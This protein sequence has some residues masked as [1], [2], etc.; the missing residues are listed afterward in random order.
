MEDRYA[1]ETREE[2][3]ARKARERAR[4]K[5]ILLIIS[6]IVVILAALIIV[7]L[8]VFLKGH[9]DAETNAIVGTEDVNSFSIT[10]VG[11]K[12]DFSAMEAAEQEARDAAAAAAAASAGLP[13]ISTDRIASTVVYMIRAE[14]EAVLVDLASTYQIY[15]ASMTKI[16]TALVAIE[17]IS[18][19]N[20]TYYFTGEEINYA[21][22]QDATL[23]GFEAGEEVPVR[24][25]I[26]GILLPSGSDASYA[27]ANYLI[28]A[29]S[30]QASEAGFVEMMNQKAR[31][32]GMADTHYTNCTGLHDNDHYTT[33]R[34]MIK[35]M[36]AALANDYFR[37]VFTSKEFTTT[38]TYTHP[39][40][41][42]MTNTTFDYL[43][44]A[45]LENGCE[46]LGGKTGYTDEAGR[47]LAS[48][49]RAADG[50][51]YML[52]TAGAFS[53]TDPYPNATDAKT[54]YGQL[55]G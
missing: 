53:N 15:P 23:A 40:G 7:V 52:V 48:F 34:D 44:N 4:M 29:G 46:I 9:M 26:Y 33:C 19:M 22:E 47:C 30:T 6:I 27:I 35:L 18:D 14:D 1:D 20:S 2:R 12:T 3:R 41:I 42:H 39:D 8:V 36:K 51:E 54:L 32:L 10:Y 21:S 38:S 11:E 50:T 25:I 37:E 16:M 43:E 13:T 55:P 49:A 5:K 28:Q 31:D 45:T 24:D 17:H